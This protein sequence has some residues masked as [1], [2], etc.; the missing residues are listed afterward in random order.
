MNSLSKTAQ[1]VFL[2]TIISVQSFAQKETEIFS[3]FDKNFAFVT[4]VFRKNS[5]SYFK[6]FAEMQLN[7]Q[8]KKMDGAKDLI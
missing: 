8:E 6:T 1:I 2:S 5:D 3:E 4:S 7:P